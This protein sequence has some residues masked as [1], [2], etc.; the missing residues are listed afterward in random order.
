MPCQPHLATTKAHRLAMQDDE[1]F[2]DDEDDQDEDDELAREGSGIIITELNH[3][4]SD[5]LG[6]DVRAVLML[7]VISMQTSCNS[8]AASKRHSLLLRWR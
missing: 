4:G 8:A 6:T 1:E 3:D 7:S 5:K 2:D